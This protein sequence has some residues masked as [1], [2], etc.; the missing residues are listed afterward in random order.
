M[1]RK[2]L[3]RITAAFFGLMICFTILSRAAYQEGTALVHTGR[4]SSM[5]ISHQVKTTGK[6]EQNQELAVT[7]EPNLRVASIAVGEGDRVSRGDLLFTLDLTMLEE[8]I[9]NQKQEMEKQQLNVEDAK[10]QKD[11][12]RQQKA[13]EQAQ[14]SE[15]YSLNTN[16]A[17]VALSRAARN[18]NQAREDLKEFRKNSGREEG[19]DTVEAALEADLE[20]K[21]Q[22]YVDAV[23]ELDSLKWQIENAVY[24]ALQAAQGGTASLESRQTV[25]TGAEDLLLEEAPQPAA[26]FQA[27]T[28]PQ[29]TASSQPAASFQAETQP[30]PESSSQPEAQPQSAASSQPETQPQPETEKSGTGQAET[31]DSLL[32]EES[33]GNLSDA[34]PEEYDPDILLEEEPILQESGETVWEPEIQ[35]EPWTENPALPETEQTEGETVSGAPPTEEEL[36]KLEQSV[37]DGYRERLEAA[38]N[39]AA[40]TLEEKNRACEALVRYQQE[41]LAAESAAEAQTEQGLLDALQ[42]AR[43]AYVDASIA[44]NEAAVTSGRAVAAAGIPQASN[45]S[46]RVNEITYEQMELQLEKLETLLENQG[47]VCAPADGLVTGIYI[48]TGGM[49]AETTAVLLA[50]L[51][52][53]YRFVG[54]ITREQEKYIGAGDLVTLTANTGRESFEELPV[55]AVRADEEKEGVYTVTVQLPEDT[56]ELGAA[57]ALDFTKKS[58]VYPV[59]VPLSALYLD[60]KNLPYVLV[61]D[62]IDTIMGTETRARKVSVTVLEQNESFAALAE[63]AVGSQEEVIVSSDKS[64]DDGSRVRLAS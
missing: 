29:P 21:T 3:M 30:Q 43:D 23:Q 37:R 46:D 62:E 44:A 52:K 63:G 32:E 24:Q 58:E 38:Q 59:C 48:Q 28:Q 4:P 9:L 39:A 10:S 40:A 6:V 51:S 36:N 15:N 14:A 12:S 54:E 20:E 55:S 42:A 7:T 61:L 49:T 8:K 35:E 41:R 2:G 25:L 57:A 19:D 56:L 27:E 26:S 47:K 64:V 17:G 60:E 18:L 1:K 5:V 34:A 16:R 13:N 22:A 31:Q 11:V 33:P 53:G 45:S 50:D